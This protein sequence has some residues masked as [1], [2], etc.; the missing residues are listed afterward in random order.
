MTEEELHTELVK[1]LRIAVK[2]D[3]VS[4]LFINALIFQDGKK[5]KALSLYSHI[6]AVSLY[7][8]SITVLF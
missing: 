5:R 4:H 2:D 3:Y 1:L 6:L 8:L 7:S